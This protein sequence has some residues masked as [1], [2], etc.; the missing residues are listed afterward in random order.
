MLS[1]CFLVICLLIS[2]FLYPVFAVEEIVLEI[3]SSKFV[4]ISNISEENL[5]RL[6]AAGVDE[7]DIFCLSRQ[8]EVY[9]PTSIQVQNYIAELIRPEG[10]YVSTQKPIKYKK[11]INGDTITP[12]G[13]IPHYDLSQKWNVSSSRAQSTLSNVTNF[14]DQTGVYYCVRSINGY[15]Q[16]TSYATL[17]NLSSV[18]SNDRPY[19]MF[20]FR[21]SNGNNVAYGDIGLVYFPGIGWKGFYNVNENGTPYEDYSF[22]FTGNNNVYFHLRFYDDA[23]DKAILIVRDA[24]TWSKVAEIKYDFATNCVESNYS[25]TKIAKEVTLAQHNSGT[26]DINTGTV[27]S[28]AQYSQ[29]Y[30]YTQSTQ[31][32]FT[33]SYCSEAYR[34]GPT[35]SAY[36]K[37]QA[38]YTPW[39]S[40]SVTIS[41]N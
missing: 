11:T 17:P 15:E 7:S 24:T 28:G 40:E 18:Y 2:V 25:S 12:F 6:R 30:L 19:Q 14:N 38:T 10:E 1:V 9:K 32:Q 31:Y 34:Q 35:A 4:K 26:L 13:I 23:E 5:N 29:T 33:S 21:T 41:F 36:G 39:T 20:T 8:I 3:D 27:M 22:G 37:V 16:M